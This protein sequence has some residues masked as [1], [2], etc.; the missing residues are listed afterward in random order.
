MA[1]PPAP[2]PSARPARRR[3][4]RYHH[5]DLRRALVQEAVRTIQTQGAEALTL[6]GVGDRL[7]VSRTALYRHFA[8]KQALLD[9]VAADGFRTLRAALRGAWDAG[10]GGRVGFDAM[11]VAYVGF[12]VTHPSHYRV[13][14]GGLARRHG[15]VEDELEESADAFR[16]L[17]D[18]IVALQRDGAMRA[19]DPQSLALY[20]WAVVHGLAMLALDGVLPE[21]V[22]VAA[23]VDAS[24]IRLWAG[25]TP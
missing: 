7:G 14:F 12:A 9:E 17:V 22:E 15:G 10:G 11:G 21:G 13:M 25:L 24:I 2:R 19:D 1:A 3:P 5:G 8:D 4:D 20:I 6:R 23:L 16:A 18:G